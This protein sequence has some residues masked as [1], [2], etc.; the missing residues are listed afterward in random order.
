MNKYGRILLPFITPFGKNEEVNYQAFEE[1]LNYAI[2][3]DYLD[4]VIVTGTTGE[5]NVLTFEEKVKLYETAVKVV[6]GR[7]P[8]I[9]GTGCA[10]T[11]ETIELTNAATKLGIDTCM[12]VAP[13]YCK[14][15]QEAIYENYLR[16]AKET[17]TNIMIYNIPIFTG[18]NIEPNTVRELIKQSK[19]FFAIKDESGINPVQITD[20]Y[21]AVKDINPEFLIFNGDDIMLMPTLAQ[22]AVG[23]VSGGSLI[24]GDKVREV[25][26]KYYEGK[27]KES[28]EIYRQIFR[29]TRALGINSRTNP[30]PALKAAVEMVTGI[31]V[32]GVRMPLNNLTEEERKYLKEVLE[33]IK[34]I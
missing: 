13:Y 15:T 29:F 16:I 18:V 23:I 6:N 25:F 12:I 17:D 27:V 34:L 3:R 2:E 33:E 5:F 32:G 24:L 8:I 1:L 31:E 7:K 11:R 20:Y 19:K 28:L 26:T 9:A 30:I 21:F 14:P 10:S 22:G 4:T